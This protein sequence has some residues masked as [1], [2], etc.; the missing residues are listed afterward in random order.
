MR[1]EYILRLALV[2]LVVGGAVRWY[3]RRTP[4]PVPVAPTPTAED[5]SQDVV[6]EASKGSFPASDPPGW[7]RIKT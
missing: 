1:G 5:V 2:G 7:I 4:A 3:R 6:E